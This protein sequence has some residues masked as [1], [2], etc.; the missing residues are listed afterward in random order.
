M[1]LESRW[2]R[3]YQ[4]YIGGEQY[5][6]LTP[7]LSALSR[8][9]IRASE[10]CVGGRLLDAGAG[11]LTYAFLMSPRVREY[12]S[13][14]IEQTDPRLSLVADVCHL[15][16]PAG[17]FDSVFCSQVLEHVAHPWD[18]MHE[19]A[20]VLRPQGILLLTVPHLAYLHGQPEDYFRYT[21]FGLARLA[22]DAGMK[23]RE[24][25]PAGGFLCFLA[26]PFSL[27]FSTLLGTMPGLS[28]PTWFLNGLFV[29]VVTTLDRYLGLRS[30]YPVNWV[31]IFVKEQHQR[32]S[33]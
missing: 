25:R 5:L 9:L 10:Q 33:S 20:R 17:S 26:E 1:D 31:A 24:I 13:L 19:F 28:K 14:D 12:V 22:A 4:R 16:F 27:I 8:E 29:K 11:P 15:P 32:D 7:T 21:Q 23:V 30:R 18:A 2:S 6:A 3:Y